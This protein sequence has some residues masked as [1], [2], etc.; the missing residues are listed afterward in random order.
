MNTYFP[1]DYLSSGPFIANIYDKQL[2]NTQ[3]Y[4]DIVI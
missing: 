3:F 4:Y 2:F 1:Y